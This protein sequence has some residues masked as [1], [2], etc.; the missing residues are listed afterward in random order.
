MFAETQLEEGNLRGNL[1]RARMARFTVR[2]WLKELG[3]DHEQKLEVEVALDRT[4]LGEVFRASA[5]VPS[6]H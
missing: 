2:Q 1:E 6:L 5:K 4:G 3:A